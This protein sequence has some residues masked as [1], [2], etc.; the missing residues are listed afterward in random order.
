MALGQQR[1]GGGLHRHDL[2]VGIF[3]LEVPAHTADGAAGAH[4]GH[5]EVHVPLRIFPDLR[6]GGAVVGLRIG[7]VIKLPGD[8]AAGGF[9]VQRLSLGHSAGHALAAG[10]QH[11]LRSIGG[12]EAAPLHAHGVRHGED[13]MVPQCGTHSGK[14]NAGVAG[15][16]FNDGG[17]GRELSLLRRP[18]NHIDSHPVLGTAGRVLAFQLRQDRGLQAMVLFIVA[19]FQKRCPADEFRYAAGDLHERSLHF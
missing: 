9:P 7:G 6:A 17:S 4:A 18:G 10:G 8:D 5:K 13:H 3:L 16:G 2:H 14:T 11:D 19:Q 1:R 12:D 15:G